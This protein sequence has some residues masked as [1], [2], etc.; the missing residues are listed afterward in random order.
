MKCA[1]AEFK[2][3]FGGKFNPIGEAQLC[4]RAI[5]DVFKEVWVEIVFKVFVG[6]GLSH[7]CCLC[8]FVLCTGNIVNWL[9]A[10]KV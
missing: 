6:K 8:V 4:I 2:Y 3:I 7:R 10:Q 1:A 5:Y 9:F